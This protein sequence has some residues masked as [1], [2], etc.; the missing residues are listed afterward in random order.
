MRQ[1]VLS[2]EYYVAHMQ[3]TWSMLSCRKFRDTCRVADWRGGDTV[4]V[5][6]WTW[7]RHGPGNT[8]EAFEAVDIIRAH[9]GQPGS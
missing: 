1:R 2:T 9:E 8:C 3:L 7:H 4:P 5:E 6:L